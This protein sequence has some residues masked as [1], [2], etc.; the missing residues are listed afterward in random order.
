[1][2]EFIVTF[3]PQDR[4]IRVK[5]GTDLL[6]AA[7]KAGVSL[8]SSCGGEGLCGKCKVIVKKGEVK[9]EPSKL[10]NE[11]DRARNAI[12]AC[13]SIVESDLEIAIPSESLELHKIESH[14]AEEFSKGVILKRE[15]AF[16][17]L[18]LIEKIYLELPEPTLDDNTSDLDRIYREIE[19]RLEGL[20]LSAKVSNVRLLGDVLRE[21]GFKVTVTIAHKE[22]A[23]EIIAIEP[24]D[25]SKH[26]LGFA[27]DIG[28]TTVVG[29]LIDLN[30]KRILGSK[31]AYNK[32]APY[33]SDVIT[34]IIYGSD[35]K[36]LEKLNGA[37]V[38]N[39]NEIIED[40]SSEFKLDMT[41]VH[42][43]VCAGNMTMMH[44][45]LEID[46]THI[47]KAPYIPTM[48]TFS[49]IH[50]SE[51]GIKMSPKGILY[52]LPGVTTYIGGDTVGGVLA[53]GIFDSDEV[54][55]LVDIG[56]NGEIVLGNREWMIGAAASAG[57][58][59]EGSGLSHGM[60]AVN[61]AIQKVKIAK[62]LDVEYETI[63]EA[64]PKG[65]CGS[66]Y[67]DLLRGML[68]NSVMTKDG[69]INSER[70]SKRIR[71]GELTY[72]FVVAFKKETATGED[73]VI[74]EDDIENLKRAKGAIYSA[75][76]SLFIKVEK[77]VSE[78]KKVYIAGGFGNYISIESAVSIG[79]LPDIDR[80]LYEYIGNS[81]LA[82]ARMSLLSR[83]ALA[84]TKDIAR[85]ITYI[86]LSSE[87]RYMDEYVAA[88]FFPHTDSGRFPSVR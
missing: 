46:P 19:R 7:L 54:A 52:C 18:P 22:G 68:K 25:T 2:E 55:L 62:S 78:V 27:F 58:S 53:S 61:G 39:I 43:V 44:F 47:R 4:K 88:L 38:D 42:A 76:L 5:R 63:G 69:K 23:C 14:D 17:H 86:D 80:S 11:K 41:N 8:N 72:E 32:Q 12:L 40:L 57:P 77:E 64:K 51:V 3:K 73:I 65:I 81:S 15:G 30:T 33:G 50:S 71:K 85:S 34:R 20:F 48:T 45:L 1:M 26:N 6:T 60:K 75:I 79:L 16:R 56:T 74:Q 66:A 59:F 49:P 84:K 24:G 10:I 31:I 37:V 87:P 70:A 13:E 29:Q 21:S 28:T 36:G 9:T 83:D 82:G 67:I 35:P